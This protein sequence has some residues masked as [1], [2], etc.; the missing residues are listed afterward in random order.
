[1]AQNAGNP[2]SCVL[3]IKGTFTQCSFLAH[4]NRHLENSVRFYRDLPLFYDVVIIY[5][6]FTGEKRENKS[7]TC[8]N[9]IAY[10]RITKP[11]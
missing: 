7:F 6:V 5:V 3:T 8:K 4:Q 1:M 2:S 9:R 11:R 10:Y